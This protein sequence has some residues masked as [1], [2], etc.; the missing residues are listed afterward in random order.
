MQWEETYAELANKMRWSIASTVSAMGINLPYR[1]S[2]GL[3]SFFASDVL[4]LL[5]L[6]DEK[7]DLD[8]LGLAK[9]EARDLDKAKR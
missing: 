9:R 6:L 4:R 5:K 8:I 2:K 1:T 7:P 3:A